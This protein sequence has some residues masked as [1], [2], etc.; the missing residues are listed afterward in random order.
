MAA[1]KNGDADLIRDLLAHD[2]IPKVKNGRVVP[3][4][5]MQVVPKFEICWLLARQGNNR[6]AASKL[7]DG[8][9]FECRTIVLL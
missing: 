9:T 3:R 5:S 6:Q 8:T 1:A 7:S 4:V 2:A